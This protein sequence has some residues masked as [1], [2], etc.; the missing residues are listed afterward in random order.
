MNYYA[1]V[2]IVDAV[3]KLGIAYAVMASPEKLLC[4]GALLLG[5]NILNFCLFFVIVTILLKV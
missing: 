3:A 2:G 1:F 5:V 4:Y